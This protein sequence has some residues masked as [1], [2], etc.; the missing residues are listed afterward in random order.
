MAFPKFRLITLLF[1]V[2]YFVLVVREFIKNN[3]ELSRFR[4]SVYLL[5]YII[6]LIFYG[7]SILRGEYYPLLLKEFLKGLLFLFI[8]LGMYQFINNKTGFGLF[9]R[10]FFRQLA[11]ISSL[12]VIFS[13][14]TYFFSSEIEF[15][16]S[17][18]IEHY[19]SLAISLTSD[20]NFYALYIILGFTSV[21]FVSKEH[22]GKYNIAG[23]LFALLLLLY[24]FTLAVSFSR[25]AL[26]VFS[27]LIVF[28]VVYFVYQQYGKK[29]YSYFSLPVLKN[30][31]VLLSVGIICISF[32]FYY[33]S[34]D[35]KKQIANDIKPDF[36][37]ELTNMVNRYRSIVK[38]DE[39]FETTYNLIWNQDSVI[40]ENSVRTNIRNKLGHW[41][42]DNPREIQQDKSDGKADTNSSAES[43]TLVAEEIESDGTQTQQA[44]NIFHDFNSVYKD[45]FLDA[46]KNSAHGQGSLEYGRTER[47]VYAL[48]MFGNYSVLNQ[49]V[50][51]GFQ[52]LKEYKQKFARK[53]ASYDYPHSPVLS[54]L[55]YSGLI[56]VGVYIFF[57]VKVIQYYWKYHS[58]LFGFAVFFII[59]VMFSFISGNSHFSIP[60]LIFITII[61]LFYRSLAVNKT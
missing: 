38:P 30:Y 12:I 31:L 23:F 24:T 43:D 21:L 44:D 16:K 45:Y 34:D 17:Y 18:N 13:I 47:W 15:F 2:G 29:K 35:L 5:P 49:F 4:K 50:G 25:R 33:V 36:T 20:Y 32:S 46:N 19:N 53:E 10:Y 39:D 51:N 7:V 28:L 61:P 27:M 37:R 54:A 14:L 1:I 48:N 22:S 3:G 57:L 6:V 41:F 55:L 11:V 8:I 58:E 60:A 40:A 9:K 26:V 42:Y 52:Y 56:G 59:T